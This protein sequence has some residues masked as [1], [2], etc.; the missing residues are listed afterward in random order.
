MQTMP[1]PA[2]AAAAANAMRLPVVEDGIIL[3][4]RGK[5]SAVSTVICQFVHISV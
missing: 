3:L 4:N 2:A 5:Y 1:Y